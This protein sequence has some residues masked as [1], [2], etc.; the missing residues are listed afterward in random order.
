MGSGGWTTLS[1]FLE[2]HGGDPTQEISAADLLPLDTRSVKVSPRRRSCAPLVSTHSTAQTT[3]NTPTFG[4]YVSSTPVSRR[5]SL[6]SPEPWMS[7]SSGY[8]SSSVGCNG[9][10]PA[11]ITTITRRRRSSTTEAACRRR[12]Q[13]HRS[14]IGGISPLPTENCM[15]SNP[16]TPTRPTSEPIKSRYPN[17]LNSSQ[18]ITNKSNGMSNSMSNGMVPLMASPSL[19]LAKQNV[20]RKAVQKSC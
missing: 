2:R 8:S 3:P 15:Q 17:Y 20:F 1:H 9:S 18:H 14:S 5:S 12:V 11:V 4:R 7:A 10:P 16:S 6:S 19:H 13:T